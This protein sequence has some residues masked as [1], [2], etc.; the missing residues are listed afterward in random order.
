MVGGC[1]SGHPP[2]AVSS[3]GVAQGYTDEVTP[4]C[5]FTHLAQPGP[6]SLLG[7]ISNS[8]A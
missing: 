4:H 2:W 6:T 7:Q 8:R 5:F 1:K 3:S